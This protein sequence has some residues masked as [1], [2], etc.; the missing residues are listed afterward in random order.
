MIETAFEV[1]AKVR[2]LRPTVAGEEAIVLEVIEP[3]PVALGEYSSALGG[4]EPGRRVSRYRVQVVRT[5]EEL[6]ERADRM[7]PILN[8]QLKG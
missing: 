1:G 7:E 3:R 6:L 5:G 4:V 8:G 2:L